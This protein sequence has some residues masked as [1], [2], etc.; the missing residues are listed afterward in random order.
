MPQQKTIVI[1][2]LLVIALATLQVRLVRRVVQPDRPQLIQGAV[3]PQFEFAGAD[4]TL[5]PASGLRGHPLVVNFWAAW[6]A[7]CRMELPDIAEAVDSWNSKAPATDRV[8]FVT[9]NAG[10]DPASLS[11]FVE[12][13]R[14]R[15]AQFAFD[16]DGSVGERWKVR[17]FP[18]TIVIDRNGVVREVQEGYD[19]SFKYRLDDL[20]KAESAAAVRP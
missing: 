20:L 7:P 6:C 17:V 10:D 9:V 1:G 19:R 11:V 5:I 15:A 12:D 18:T 14:L 16:R 13:R 3:A 2:G 4:G 8:H